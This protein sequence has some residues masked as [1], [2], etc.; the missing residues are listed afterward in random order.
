MWE[1][2]A[3]FFASGPITSAGHM[4]ID[5]NEMICMENRQLRTDLSELFGIPIVFLF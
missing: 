4:N 5:I 3:I 2:I 1:L